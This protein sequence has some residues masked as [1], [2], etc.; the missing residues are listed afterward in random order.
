M[1]E[2]TGGIVIA[3]EAEGRMGML[4]DAGDAMVNSGKLL[5][6]YRPPLSL[7]GGCWSM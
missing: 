4:A 2:E 3:L 1:S 6:L 7:G 5:P